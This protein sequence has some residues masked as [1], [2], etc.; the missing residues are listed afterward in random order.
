M[1]RTKIMQHQSQLDLR[2]EDV[3]YKHVTGD[4]KQKLEIVA[5]S[6]TGDP[7][8]QA[9]FGHPTITRWKGKPVRIT[10]EEL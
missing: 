9:L 1:P 2:L 8:M 5:Q 10:I 7:W 6:V 3:A 4:C